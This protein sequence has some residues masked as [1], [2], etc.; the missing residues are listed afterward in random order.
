MLGIFSG[1]AQSDDP[2]RE[3]RIQEGPAN[4]FWRIGVHGCDVVVTYGRIGTRGQTL[5]K[6]YETE[7]RAEREVNKLTAEKQRKGCAEHAIAP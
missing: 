7:D 2:T 5:T 4:K 6:S 3:F 1:H